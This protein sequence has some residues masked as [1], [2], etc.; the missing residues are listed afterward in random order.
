MVRLGFNRVSLYPNSGIIYENH[1]GIVEFNGVCN[2]GNAS[3]I[4]IG[5]KGCLIFGRHFDAT[6]SFRVACYHNIQFGDYV[7][8][9]WDCTFLDTDF[10]KLQQMTRRGFGSI[11]VGDNVWLTQR[12]IVLKNT[13]VSNGCVIAPGSSTNRHYEEPNCLLAGSPA[14]IVLRGV[15]RNPQNDELNYDD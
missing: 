7:L 4:S 15:C 12:C 2:I 3:A 1:G 8:V 9:G 11:V 6:T 10:H 5:N 14:K 13:V